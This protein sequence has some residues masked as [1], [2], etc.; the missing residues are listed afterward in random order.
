MKI[1]TVVGT[2]PELIRLH[3]IIKKLDELVQHFLLYTN[4]NF[5]Y[6]LSGRFFKDLKI[7]EPD[8]TLPGPCGS[9]G[10][11]LGAAIFDF[12]RILLK[13][14]PDK[15]LILGDTNSGLLALVANRYKIPIIHMEA[16]SRAFD[17]RVPEETNRKI[18]DMLSTYNL[19]YTE[20]S[21]QNLINEG[22]CKNYIFKT[23]N[24]IYEV[25]N[26]WK[27][28]IDS[29]NVV[30]DLGL[31]AVP[32]VLVTFHRAENV[33]N[34]ESL[35]NIVRLV[36]KMSEQYKVV[37]SLHPRT[38]DKMSKYDLIF[39]PK[40]VIVSSSLG[41]FEFNKLSKTADLLVSDSGSNPEISCLFGIPSLIIRESTE[42]QEL[43]ECGSS[44]LTGTKYE[45]MLESFNLIQKRDNK[46]IPP[47]D[48]LVENVS[49]IVINILLG[50]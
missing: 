6:D 3:L 18:I 42:R 39:H 13:E 36:N 23:G 32:F 43:I 22:Y 44:I 8:Y 49:D 26:Y 24:P 16:G 28:E 5:D 7:R 34:R 11:F 14:K 10:E 50:K 41:F 35:T 21:K 45:N 38:K 46:W 20:N 40:N 37:V 25:L 27:D 1:L 47:A 15:I 29:S 31:N 12:E 48:Y 33:D 9:F 17:P 19:P 4:Q 30:N 2:R